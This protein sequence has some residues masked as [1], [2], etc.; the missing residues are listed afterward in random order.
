MF[1]D[2]NSLLCCKAFEGFTEKMNDRVGWSGN[3]LIGNWYTPIIM[4]D[5]GSLK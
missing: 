3:L 1:K 4:R 2:S 5:K